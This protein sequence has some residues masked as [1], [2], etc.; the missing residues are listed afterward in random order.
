MKRATQQETAQ[1][2]GISTTTLKRYA[3]K[4]R[5]LLQVGLVYLQQQKKEALDARATRN[6]TEK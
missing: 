5:E 6:Q 4:E 2:L 1:Y 3:T